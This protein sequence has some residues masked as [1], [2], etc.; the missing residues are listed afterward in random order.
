[1]NP[2]KHPDFPAVLLV[3]DSPLFPIHWLNDAIFCEYKLYLVNRRDSDVPRTLVMDEGKSEHADL[4]VHFAQTA[5]AG[6]L[7]EMLETSRSE[8]IHSREF[9]VVSRN[10][11]IYGRIDDLVCGPDS[12]IIIDDKRNPSLFESDKRQVQGYCLAIKDILGMQDPR[13]IFAAL[14]RTGTSDLTWKEKFGEQ[15]ERTVNNTIQRVHS[16][17]SGEAQFKPARNP[18][19]CVKCRC[20]SVCTKVAL[21]KK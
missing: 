3:D 17:I 11:G 1:M 2:A 13:P 18:A 19:K 7:A 20:K 4:Y 16:L 8:V 6:S 12:Y 14:R 10:Y 21:K 5:V 15:A 9:P